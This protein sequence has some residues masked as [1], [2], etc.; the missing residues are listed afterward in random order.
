MGGCGQQFRAGQY[1]REF[2]NTDWD[3]DYEDEGP[4]PAYW[5]YVK[6]AACHWLVNFH[7]TLAMLV[8]PDREWRILSD[9]KHS[10]VWDGRNTLFDFNFLALGVPAATAFSLAKEGIEYKPGKL[11]RV[12]YHLHYSACVVVF[13]LAEMGFA[14]FLQE[15]GKSTRLKMIEALQD[16]RASAL[17]LASSSG[18]YDIDDRTQLDDPRIENKVRVDQFQVV[19]GVA[20]G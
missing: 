10:T 5:M 19:S 18:V 14:V 16:A 4:E 13:P 15:L 17:N 11:M 6:H 8:E 9:R 2:E 1:P 12:G 20:P 3:V 7:L